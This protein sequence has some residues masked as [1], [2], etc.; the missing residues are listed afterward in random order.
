MLS[1]IT[2][3]YI[4]ARYGNKL[5]DSKIIHE[6][7]DCWNTLRKYK[8]KFISNASSKKLVQQKEVNTNL[9]QVK[10]IQG[11]KKNYKSSLVH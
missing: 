2:D 1:R 5:E 4:V 8:I 9:E 7:K 3:A 10:K 6:I 11:I